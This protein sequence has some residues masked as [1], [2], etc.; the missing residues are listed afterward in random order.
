[1]TPHVSPR[2]RAMPASPIRKL[3][4]VAEEAKRRGTR[5]LHLNIGQPDLETPA[6]MRQRLERVDRTIAYTPSG[7]TPE[8]LDPLVEYHRRLGIALDAT[9]L[10]ATTGGSEALLFAFFATTSDG[11]EALTVEL[12]IEVPVQVNGKTRGKVTVQRGAREDD[13]VAAALRDEAVK[14]FT[15]GQSIKKRIWV[16]D[17]LLNLVVGNSN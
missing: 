6:V 7:G 4:P 8:Y 3:M 16:Q 17:R 12:K 1:M 9:D 14:R 10:V 5:V 11:D 13:V 15:E 2:G